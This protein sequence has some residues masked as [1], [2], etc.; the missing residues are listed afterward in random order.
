[1]VPKKIVAKVVKRFYLLLVA[2]SI[3]VLFCSC[4]TTE[5]QNVNT[6]TEYT[7][8]KYKFSVSDTWEL[9]TEESDGAYYFSNGTDVICV[10][11]DKIPGNLAVTVNDGPYKASVA[12][13]LQ[14]SMPG[15]V[16]DEYEE[17]NQEGIKQKG[18]E[19]SVL[20]KCT[21]IVSGE[22]NEI[23]LYLLED[24]AKTVTNI[25]VIM[26]EGS[27]R[28]GLEEAREIIDTLE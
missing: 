1:M 6:R 16:V 27:D 2:V 15:L 19:H 14:S 21:A 13:Q 22:N 7:L 3:P 11:M 9:S 4:A 20:C 12:S 23:W 8:D 26:P 18:F 17:Y 24:E 25:M 10:N 28:A 5:K